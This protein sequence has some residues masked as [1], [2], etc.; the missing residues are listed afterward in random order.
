MR[1]VFGPPLAADLYSDAKAIVM[2]YMKLS[3]KEL[4]E[5]ALLWIALEI[6]IALYIMM[7]LGIPGLAK[8]FCEHLPM[9]ECDEIDWEYYGEEEPKYK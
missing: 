9:D 1:K 3:K 6:V 7:E 2:R 8:K 5:F 4:K